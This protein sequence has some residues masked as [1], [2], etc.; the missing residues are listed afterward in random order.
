MADYLSLQNATLISSWSRRD[1]NHRIVH[2]SSGWLETEMK[3]DKEVELIL[4]KRA[5]Q[6]QSFFQ[7]SK[8][9]SLN[10]VLPRYTAL[11]KHLEIQEKKP[12]SEL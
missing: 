11:V 2:D 7:L 10:Y 4:N 5:M 9:Q 8:M 12:T 3:I 1:S 6:H